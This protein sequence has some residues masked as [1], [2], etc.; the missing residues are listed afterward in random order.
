MST[1][2]STATGSSSTV[3]SCCPRPTS[4]DT[5]VG[6][7]ASMRSHASPTS[8]AEVMQCDKD[9]FNKFFQ[10]MLDRGV[11]L[12]PSQFEAAFV[13]AAHSPSDIEKTLAAADAAFHE[14]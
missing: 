12:A 8:F 3:A 11:Y 13:S 10:A 14:V 4:V 5:Q 9:M 2:S 6:S 1:I 7:A